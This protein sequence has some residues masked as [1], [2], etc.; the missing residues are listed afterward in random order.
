MAAE[1]FKAAREFLLANRTDYAT[2]YAQFRW[3]ELENFNW[4]LDW[5]DA[6]LARGPL[7]DSPALRIVGAGAT[8]LSFRQL[9]ERSNRVANGLRDIGIQR[10]DRVLVMLGNV[11]P[12]WEVMLA[13]MKLGAV[14]VPAT[15]LLTAADLAERVT[16]ARV[17]CLVTLSADEQGKW[18]TLFKQVRTRLAQGT[19]S[20]AL[21]AKLE[22]YAK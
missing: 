4:A 18:A 8:E 21:V 22:T 13:A 20:A 14:V 6:D 9:A 12:L 17:R 2:A 11:A 16:R 3:P 1:A 10:G 7:A 19:F 15:T 5:F